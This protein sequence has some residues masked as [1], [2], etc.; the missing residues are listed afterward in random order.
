MM[1]LPLCVCLPCTCCRGTVIFGFE[2]ATKYTV[3][4]QD[5]TVV[6]LMA[7]QVTGLG[8]EIARQLLRTRRSFTSTVLSPDGR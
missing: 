2:Q 7:E 5:G 8:N 6:A 3:Y 4:D 1:V